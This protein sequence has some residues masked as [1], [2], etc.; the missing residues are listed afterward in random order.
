LPSTKKTDGTEKKFVIPSSAE[1]YEYLLAEV[2]KAKKHMEENARPTQTNS[3]T[4]E[5]SGK[6]SFATQTTEI[7]SLGVDSDKAGMVDV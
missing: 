3:Q 7:S 5:T 2:L 6:R 4:I 1:V